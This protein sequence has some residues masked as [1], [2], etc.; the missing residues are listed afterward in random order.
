MVTNAR[1]L[2]GPVLFAYDGSA[3]ARSAIERAG[4]ELRVGREAVVLNVWGPPISPATEF[5]ETEL[6]NELADQAR[7]VAAEGAALASEAGFE[8]VPL[9][10]LGVSAWGKI[11]EMADEHDASLVV[12][13]SRG[14]SGITHVLIGSVAAAVVQHTD[15][16]VLIVH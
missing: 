8:A 6:A 4:Q 3:Q 13:G 7:K 9:A 12:M 10:E 14:L 5:M 1:N 15:R 11:V 2:E 16:P